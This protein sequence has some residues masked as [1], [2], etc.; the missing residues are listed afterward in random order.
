MTYEEALNYMEKASAKGNKKGLPSV[1]EA[2]SLLG[3][4]HEKLRF[5]HVAGTNGKGS[6]VAL[7]SSVLI[8]SGMKVG[9]FTS[10][11]LDKYNE[12]IAINGEPISDDD[13]VSSIECIRDITESLFGKGSSFSFF[14]LLTIMAFD[15]FY[16]NDVDVAV[17]EVGLG[18]RL[19]STN[20]LKNPMLCVITTI[21]FDHMAILGNTLEQISLE[22]AGI[23]K[24]NSPTLLYSCTNSVYNT[25]KEVADGRGAPFYCC[26]EFQTTVLSRTLTETTFNLKVDFDGGFY[27]ECLTIPLLGEYQVYNAQN[28]FIACLLLKKY[29]LNISL[30]DIKNG[31][32]N[33]SWP[34]RAEIFGGEGRPLLI[35]DGAHNVEGCKAHKKNLSIYFKDKRIISIIG[36]L[37]DKEYEKMLPLLSGDINILCGIKSERALLPEEL[38]QYIKSDYIAENAEIALEK[39]LSL[40][41]TDTIISVS[42]SL[43][44]IAE[45]RRLIKHIRLN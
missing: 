11:H 39:A 45:F 21:G 22:K 44:L 26:T 10:P 38:S 20:I 28:A 33:V 5:V 6:T 25:I 15:Y 18:G 2:L 16:R 34:G 30:N 12:R 13:F 9:V 23:I 7:I 40:C 37:R 32:K 8:E 1:A 31:F 36:M 27:D 19:D 3:S 17:I 41:D 4:P 24:E 14:E 35:L 42:G 43:Y 29:G